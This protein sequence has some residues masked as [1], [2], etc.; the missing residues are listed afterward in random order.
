[1]PRRP[2]KIL[3]SFDFTQHFFASSSLWSSEKNHRLF[4]LHSSWEWRVDFFCQTSGFWRL[5]FLD[6]FNLGWIC[7]HGRV[8]NSIKIQNWCSKFWKLKFE[9]LRWNL[10]LQLKI[11]KKLR[12]INLLV[13]VL[14]KQFSKWD[15]NT[16]GDTWLGL[17]ALIKLHSLLVSSYIILSV[18]R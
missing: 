4:D 18:I 6:W 2:K 5:I 3:R 16:L 8:G 17:S 7:L 1:M 14:T 10:K 12:R 15:L 9:L 13:L 11:M